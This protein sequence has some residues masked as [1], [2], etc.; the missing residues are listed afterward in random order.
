MYATGACA[1]M[2]VHAGQPLS[3]TLSGSASH[4]RAMAAARAS[5]YTRHS[6]VI[7]MAAQQAVGSMKASLTRLHALDAVVEGHARLR[8][9]LEPHLHPP[10]R[11]LARAPLG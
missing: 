5:S 6:Q 2:A 7:R 3:R 4:T 8:P 10:R 9:V 11:P 1:R